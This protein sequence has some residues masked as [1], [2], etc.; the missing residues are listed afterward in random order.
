MFSVTTLFWKSQSRILKPFCQRAPKVSHDLLLVVPLANITTIGLITQKILEVF[1]ILGH[2]HQCYHRT[3]S[4]NKCQS[5]GIKLL[6]FFLKA[7][8]FPH[9]SPGLFASLSAGKFWE[10]LSQ[11]SQQ[12][13]SIRT[14]TKTLACGLHAKLSRLKI[15]THLPALVGFLLMKNNKFAGIYLR[16]CS[17]PRWKHWTLKC[18]TCQMLKRENNKK[19]EARL[20]KEPPLELL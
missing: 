18:H 8:S 13:D 16:E 1:R 12:W 3:L 9:C 14:H 15:S 4:H 7:L 5:Q 10:Q 19:Y 6:S 17:T 11:S 20:L 2:H